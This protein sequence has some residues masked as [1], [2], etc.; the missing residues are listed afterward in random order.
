ML[1]IVRWTPAPSKLGENLALRAI[2]LDLQAENVE[3][4]KWMTSLLIASP[5]V[6]SVTFIISEAY[7]VFLLDEAPA[8]FDQWLRIDDA[9]MRQSELVS[10]LEVVFEIFARN[11]MAFRK[12]KEI[13]AFLPRLTKAGI[14]K[15]TGVCKLE[16]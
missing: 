15:L 13:K 4:L 3:V 9:L 2:T 16:N 8:I 6:S 11:D 10:G 12:V 14:V 1:Q 5:V 7:F